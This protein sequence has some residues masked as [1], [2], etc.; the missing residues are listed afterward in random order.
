MNESAG[1]RVRKVEFDDG[2]VIRRD[3]EIPDRWYWFPKVGQPP[4]GVERSCELA[5]ASLSKL[6]YGKSIQRD[7]A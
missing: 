1:L 4:W 3:R 5:V 7:K 6:G 2:S